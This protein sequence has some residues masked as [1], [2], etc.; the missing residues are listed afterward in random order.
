MCT[1]VVGIYFSKNKKIPVIGF[2][3]F[4][5]TVYTVG[6]EPDISCVARKIKKKNY[7]M[8]VHNQIC[9]WVGVYMQGDV[10]SSVYKKCKRQKVLLCSKNLGNATEWY[11]EVK[12]LMQ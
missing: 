4:S 3:S 8:G 2:S 6:D 9:L 10:C 7:Q 12:I 1:T 5:R 11:R